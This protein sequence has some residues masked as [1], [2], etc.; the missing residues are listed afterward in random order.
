[1]KEMILTYI[2]EDPYYLYNLQ[3]IDITDKQLK[4]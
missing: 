1:M 3:N 2:W 4:R